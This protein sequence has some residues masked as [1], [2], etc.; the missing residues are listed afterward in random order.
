MSDEELG[1]AINNP[2]DGEKVK[3]RGNTVFDGNTRIN[4]AKGRGWTDDTEIQVEEFP[5]VPNDTDD[6][7]GPYRD[8]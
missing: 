5:E 3:V 8:Y 4:E 2:E 7:L 6:P 1:E